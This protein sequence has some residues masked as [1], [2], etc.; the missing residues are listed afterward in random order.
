[1]TAAALVCGSCG[2]E[3]PP[4]SK[5]CNECGAAVATATT[6]AEYK[7]VT[8]L[9]ADVVHSMDIATAVGAERLRE[10][11]TE[12]VNRSAAV[13]KRYDGTVDKFTGDGIMAVFGAPVALED[14]AMRACLA[15]LDIHNETARLA[16]QVD[17]DDGVTL[18]LRIGLNSGAV[19]AGE[20][21]SGPLGYTAIGEQV[22]M[23]QRMES[24]APPGGVM[25]S[26]ST[27]RLVEHATLLAEAEKVHI[28]GSDAA[29]VARRLRGVAP[30]R[31]QTV[32]WQQ[33]LIGRDLEVT[34]ISGLL[35]RSIGGRGC[36]LCIAGPAGI[37]KTRLVGEA[38]RLAKGRDVDAFS[39][40]CESHATDI[41]FRVV[42]RLLRSAAGVVGLAED[43]ARAQ[44]REQV[45]DADPEDLLLLYDLLG[46]ADP[47]AALPSI[48]P[49]ARRRRLTALVN[50][51]SL[52]R[53]KPA[54]Y[55]IEDAH[56][57]DH[58]SE[59]MLAEFFTI[60]PQTPSMVVITYRP[61]YEGA[62]TR[63]HGAQTIALAPLSD[64]ETSALVSGLL[65]PD[66]SVGELGEAIVARAAGNP[67][68]AQEMIRDLAER[69]VLQG[70]SGGYV[71]HTDMAEVSV[72]ATLQA[73]IAA[74][75]DRL[76]TR[77]KKTINAAAVTGLRFTSS[78]LAVLG[79]DPVLDELVKAELIDQVRFTPRAEYAFHH[80]LI[81]TV[82]YES[83]LKSNRAQLHRRVA[84]AIA[85]PDPAAAEENAALIAEHFEAAGDLN[86]AYEWHMRAA[87]LVDSRDVRAARTSWQ[88]AGQLA[89]RLPV[90]DPERMARRIAPRLR[91][92]SSA[93]RI[94]ADVADAG[95]DELEELCT[96]AADPVS[97]AFGL[98]GLLVVLVLRDR[99]ADAAC[100]A[101]VLESLVESIGDPTLTVL[102]VGGSNAKWQGGEPREGLRMAQVGIDLAVDDS[103]AAYFGVGA[104]LAITHSLRGSCRF[105]LGLPGW[106]KDLDEGIAAARGVDP[107]AYAATNMYKHVFAAQNG[108][109]LPDSAAE[110][111]TAEAL[112]GA[113]K[114]SNDFAFEVALISHGLVL[115]Y[116]GGPQRGEGYELLNHAREARLRRQPSAKAVRIIDTEIAREKARLGDFDGAIQVGRANVDFLFDSG[117]MTSRGPAATVVVEALLQRG[118][119]ADLR[120]AEATI[121]R[122]A[123][124]PTDPGFVL[125][126][127]P[128]LR[129][130]ALLARAHG[131]DTSYREYRGGYRNMATSL[132]FEG[133]MKWA[134]AMP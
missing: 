56:W 7:Q 37:G 32:S 120:E 46:I 39:T 36:V 68:F 84:E 123:A 106:R 41:A 94:W 48:D 31:E 97:K 49:D 133:H 129:L 77:A 40:F 38:V 105:S 45:P 103:A 86:A 28:K 132:G 111:D 108:V 30:Q 34:T 90:D 127:L 2:T 128:L 116:R 85:L 67:F 3:L 87:T 126:E 6:S 24:A 102:V 54:L 60:I 42:A 89:D 16:Q 80:P 55:V 75:I 64:S 47:E 51:A 124:V 5:F 101:S 18:Q 117:D 43:D 72:P 83:Q 61:E 19:I 57:I 65:G 63:M 125:H 121:E 17:R 73:A 91:L 107:T 52:A 74:R 35:D 27:A 11:M 122:L 78:L 13:V 20:I 59:S 114:A 99:F 33:P 22:G 95:F 100:A 93:W 112:E 115:I 50:A 70:T 29:V 92:C 53:T 119:D 118:T 69:G 131:D 8:V 44:V 104:L 58:V 113:R 96:E 9:F 14:H 23:A 66:S 25:L 79:V 76:G 12:L 130:R 15:A 110:H 98:S 21:G 26:E 82:A 81:R 134:E 71:C 4:N 88:R 10:I 62:L 109:V 1:M